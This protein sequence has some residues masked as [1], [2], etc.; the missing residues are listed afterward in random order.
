VSGTTTLNYE[1]SYLCPVCRHGHISGLTLM[2]AFACD[3]CRHIFTGNLKEQTVQVV[4]SSQPMSWRWTGRRW[5]FAYQ[6][7]LNLST[8]IWLIGIVVTT[9]PPALVWFAAYIFPPLP[10][11]RWAWFPMAWAGC[12]LVIHLVMVGWLMA[13]HYQF[14]LYVSSKVWLRMTLN[15]QH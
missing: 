7:D 5:Q 3:F 11:S 10:D 6:D 14:P 2:D 8:L 13:E 15:R 4:D 12:T 9:L 1:E